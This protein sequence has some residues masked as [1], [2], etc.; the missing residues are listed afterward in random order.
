M[1]KELTQAQDRA[2]ARLAA[3]GTWWSG[4]ERVAI[5][6]E[7]RHATHCQL[8]ARR[9]AALS[10]AGVEGVH[11]SLGALAP[12]VVDA[13]HRIR[14][15]SGRLS[16]RWLD[17]LRQQGL[18]DERYVELVGVVATVIAVDTFQ[19]AL[20]LPPRALPAAQAGSPTRRR[21]AGARID[22][23]WV[24][25]LAP[26]DV[27]PDDPPLYDGLAG[28]NIHRA[29]SLVP[30]EVIG[31]FDLDSVMYLPDRQLRDYGTEYRALSHAQIE[32]LAARMSA[33]NR[34]VY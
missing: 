32:L 15:D 23:A 30:A 25:T 10:P 17:G 11:D 28:M 5:A 22:R 4:A 8:C 24:P 12:A 6:A 7:T 2:W 29:L 14:T 9:A 13:V 26:E 33:L 19:H 27:G 3:A 21:P 1:R 31:F 34:C 18:D 16:Q 20:G